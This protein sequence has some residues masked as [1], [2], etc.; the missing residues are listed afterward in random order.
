ME[1]NFIKVDKWGTCLWGIDDTGRLFINGGEAESVSDSG[2][3]WEN[4]KQVITEAVAIGKVSFPDGASLAKLFKGCKGLEKADLSDFVTDNVVD[5]HSMFEGCVRLKDLDICN[6]NTHRCHNMNKMFT[7]CARLTNMIIGQDFSLTGDGTTSCDRLAVKETGKYKRA[8]TISAE[9]SVISYYQNGG[10]DE[11]QERKTL[12]EYSYVLEDVMFEAPDNRSVFIGWN[13]E[14]DGKGTLYKP[15]DELL[16]VDEDMD[17]FATWAK[18]PEIGEVRPI[19]EF[20]FGE[21]IPFE[22]PQIVSVNDPTV[23]GYLE[24]SPDG[25][26]DNWKAI[27]HD[28]ILPV[29]FD[30][31]YLRLH[32][33]N[34]VGETTSN[35]VRLHIRKANIDMSGVRWCEDPEMVYD[36]TRKHVWIE[37]LPKG[38]TPVYTNNEGVNAGRYTATVRLDYDQEN[39]NEPIIVKEHDWSIKKA[40]IDTSRMHWNYNRAFEYNGSEHE[41]RLNNVPAGVEVSYQGNTGKDVGVY[42]A[43]ATFSYDET[44]FERPLD[45]VPRVW[46]IT[47]APV[48][49]GSLKWS[50]YKDFVYDGEPK[51]VWIT[52]L[53]PDAIVEYEGC[54]ETPAGKYLARANLFGNY[55]STGPIEYEWEIDKARYDLSS[56]AW[57]YE[58][59]F[60]YDGK[61]HSVEL[62]GLPPELGVKYENNTAVDSGD[63]IARARFVNPNTHN[64][65]TPQ[66]VGVRWSV[67]KSAP[68]MSG[69][70]WDY[71][72]PF[73]YDGEI[74]RI[75]LVGLPEGVYAEYENNAA[76]NAG[77]YVAHA[78]LKYDA[79]NVEVSQP[80][81]CQWKIDKEKIDV[82]NVYW[83]YTSAF[84]YDGADHGVFLT[85]VPAGLNV[86]YTDNLKVEAGKYVATATLIPVDPANYETP[87]VNGCTWAI[88]KAQIE[89]DDFEWTDF[90][91]FVYDGTEKEVKIISDIGD[92]IKVDYVFN[93]QKNAG[94]YY[95]KAIFSAVDENNFIPPKPVGYSWTIERAEYDM[96]GVVW[97]YTSEF[98]YDGNRKSVRLINVPE[99]LQVSYTNADQTAAGE[100]VAVA[101]FIVTDTDNYSVN[102]PDMTLYWKIAKAAYD[103]SAVRWQYEKSFIFDGSEKSVRLTG[104]PDGLEPIYSDNSAILAG[105]YTAKVN[106]EYDKDN[107]EEPGIPECRWQIEKAPVDLTGITWD[108]ESAFVYDGTEKTVELKRL[109][110][111]SYAEYS[112]SKATQAGTY[113]AAADVISNDP[114]NR[115]TSRM[116]N[117]VWRIEKGDYDM[118]HVYWDYDAPFTYDG[119]EHTVV[120]KGLPAGVTPVYRYNS[121]IDAGV[122]EAT[123]SFRI[124]DERNYKVPEFDSCRW[125]INKADYDMS[126]VQ[127]NYGG[128]Y[129]YTGRMYEVVLRGLPEE[130]RVVY[131][132]N[133]AALTG[134]YEASADIIPYDSDNYNKPYVNNC[135]WEIVKA[136]YEMSAVRWDYTNPKVFNGR[137]QNVMLEHL[138]TGVI[139][140][141]VENEAVDVGEY[142]ARAILKV[143]D[144]ANYNIPHVEDC[145][146]EIVKADYN[147]SVV[148]WNYMP[149]D[150]VYNGRR[151]RIELEN[152]PDS[153][154]ASYEGNTG[155]HAG[156]YLATASFRTND[157]NFNAPETVTFPWSIG[158]TEYDMSLVRWD[159]TSE[160]TY[161]KTPKRVELLGLPEGV[162]VEYENN[163]AIDAGTYIAIA[164][165][166]TASEDY[167]VPEDMICRWTIN[168]ADADIRR[169]RWDYSQPFVYDGSVKSVEL[170]GVPSTLRVEYTGSEAKRV[171]RYNAHADLIPID[172]ANYNVPTIGDCQWDII[173]ADYDMSD[174]RWFGDM[175]YTYDGSAKSITLIGLPEGVE[176]VYSNNVATEVGTYTAKA[177]A[178]YDE[179]NYNK[180]EIEEQ[181]WCITK[182]SYDMSQVYWDYDDNY[183]YDG[184][185]KTVTLRNLPAGV[186][187]VYS[188]NKGI[189]A[190]DYEAYVSFSSYD[191]RNYYKPEFPGCG[192]TIEL[193]ENPAVLGDIKWNYK[194]PFTYDGTQKGVAL[195]ERVVEQGFM[196]RLR[197]RSEV[198]EIEGV[199]EGFDVIY[200]N[201][202]ATNAGVYYATARLV[203][204]ENHNYKDFIVNECRWEIV[205]AVPDMSEVR[206]DYRGA[207]TYDGGEKRVE[208]LG[209]PDS[210][211]VTYTNNAAT[212]A[213]EY[214]AL[215][216]LMAKDPVNWEM[217][218]PVKG[219]WWQID[220]ARYDM[221]HAEWDY[222]DNIVYN[223]KEK[224][225]RVV[226][227]PEGVRVEAYRGNKGLEAGNY[228][229]EAVLGYR[230]AENFEEPSLPNLKW[231]IHK[232][233]ISTENVRWN[234]DESSA[235]VY[236]GKPKEV[237]LVGVPSEV[238][239]SYIDNV[240]SNA[241]VYTARARLSYDV[242]N[243][244]VEDIAD[245]RWRIDRATYD[246]SKVR[247]SYEGP[248]VYDGY[249][250]NIALLN[251][252]GGIDVRYRDNKASSPGTYTAKAYLTYDSENYNTP[253]IDTTIDWEILQKD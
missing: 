92:D 219:C 101:R 143:T 110:D 154:V 21:T 35:P 20:T 6:F 32:A 212:N 137:P 145:V 31:Y 93:V 4:Y 88:N 182:A 214:E 249:E 131:E 230:N 116:D 252:P 196:D 38:V 127:W 138:P 9:G 66:D 189:D 253:D 198:V 8:K 18:A 117:L 245:L 84:V 120:L 118:S 48:E 236:D 220:K 243:C 111:D 53:P 200:E 91:D 87:E 241:G 141:Y 199:P 227:L 140:E 76:Y 46:E 134:K 36:G 108:Y 135:S 15:G 168:R 69:V 190:G 237:R 128:E 70:R 185:V 235:Q 12:P 206:W 59:P 2:V 217:P 205:K 175:Q 41:V 162:S 180:P 215:A 82:S 122:Y 142:T 97:D 229:A 191:D 1:K 105:E 119:D 71:S 144:E 78:T 218:K 160:F 246:T 159:Y 90:S 247:W 123:V 155:V 34:K 25:Y 201:N 58:G 57:D 3:P 225:V 250:K 171:G 39:F 81:D 251:V 194:G 26:E 17:L 157:A 130:V 231:R 64:Y 152:L 29:S 16:M 10:R 94:R 125:V 195:T 7:K 42:T 44:N 28:A 165:F 158:K 113:V 164:R 184:S 163:T 167:I 156:D 13:T 37:G 172:P 239:V 203:N 23:M 72:G 89:K 126:T 98:S 63:Y 75:S 149:G 181:V 99:G 204:R 221:S 14:A 248:F 210:V 192:W 33:T 228:L 234:Y 109:P 147:M 61:A 136:D 50:G 49:P 62:T 226:G 121:A 193:A 47:K 30:G 96:K 77:I 106:F 60:T 52:N 24:I 148:A 187:P 11:V 173:K 150:F 74:K 80:S 112:N 153:V 102:I 202:V 161:D 238:E 151:H 86:E 197:G 68:D 100:Y 224:T 186:T 208:L 85:N 179:V 216:V 115:L 240:K 188:G 56:A 51:S 139:A 67:T 207:F 183:V 242:R 27:S 177:K 169:V 124:A 129:K 223:G 176:P 209:V 19:R 40:S 211:V 79:A 5:M 65:Y 45:P 213:G 166:S 114:D 73:T 22:L 55:Y 146:W 170:A 233:K 83:D 178:I 95:A 107:Y 174:V 132:G 133:V 222:E 244:E 43:V 54:E 232:M 104:L 103:L